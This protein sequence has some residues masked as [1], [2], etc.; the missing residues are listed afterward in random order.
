MTFSVRRGVL[1]GSLLALASAAR[2][3]TPAYRVQ[4]LPTPDNCEA[5]SVGGVASFL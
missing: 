5:Y 2:A 3:G 1:V 4:V